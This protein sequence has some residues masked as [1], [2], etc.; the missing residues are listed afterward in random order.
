MISITFIAKNVTKYDYSLKIDKRGLLVLT[1]VN[2]F[3]IIPFKIPLD[4]FAS[5]EGVLK[6]CRYG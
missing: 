1:V 2:C 5:S 4:S 3:Y 6:F